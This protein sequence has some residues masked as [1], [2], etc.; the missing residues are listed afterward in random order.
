MRTARATVHG[1][2]SVVNAIATGRGVTLGTSLPTTATVSASPGRGISV[3]SG[4]V[5][6]LLTMTVKNV[7]PPTELAHNHI[8]ISISTHVPSGYGLKTSSSTSTA[9][10]MA[11]AALFNPDLDKQDILRAGVD[12]SIRSGVSITGAYDDACGCFYGGFNVTNNTSLE[13]IKQYGAPSSLLAIIFIPTARRRKNIRKLKKMAGI[14]NYAWHLS[15]EGHHWQAMIINGL[16]VSHVTGSDPYLLD[17]L[18]REGA[19]AASMSGNGPAVAAIARSDDERN[20]KKVFW[21]MDGR[22]IVSP[23]SNTEASCHE[24]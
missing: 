3:H 4:H 13:L 7:V 1:A 6:R 11:C 17:L 16:A 12:A 22:V 5:T 14:L 2:I 20:I 15:R 9:V 10:A 23:L 21:N 8:S 18:L 19:I 24:L